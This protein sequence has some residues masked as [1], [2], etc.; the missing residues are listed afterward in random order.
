MSSLIGIFDIDNVGKRWGVRILFLF[1]M[2]IMAAVE[3]NPMADSDFSLLNGWLIDYIDT[4]AKNPM[5]QMNTLPPFTEGNIIYIITLFIAFFILLTASY[6]YSALYVREFRKV[7]MEVLGKGKASPEVLDYSSRQLPSSP[8]EP[9]KLVGRVALLVLVSLAI[10]LPLMIIA[11]NFSFFLLLGLPFIFTI[12][13]AYLSGDKGLFTAI[14]YSV[15]LSSKYYFVNMRYIA[16]IFFVGLVTSFILGIASNIS[17]TAYYILDSA[18]TT[19]LFFS[20]A[21]LAG[22]AYCNMRDIP[23]NRG[24]RPLAI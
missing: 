15:K 2:V 5:A 12:P 9:K 10:F 20:F 16:V 24:R 8:I 17:L 11:L 14:P 19:W 21:R 6:I 4:M 18:V 23:A 22:V 7:R 3:F 13:V 1:T